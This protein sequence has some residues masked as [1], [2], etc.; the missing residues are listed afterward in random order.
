MT[1]QELNKKVDSFVAKYNGKTKGYP[2]DSQFSGECLSI[3]KL[4]IKEIFGISP[5][6]SGTNSAYGYWT[7]FPN[8]LGEVF[9]KVSY[10]KEAV[11][12]KGSIPIWKPT[13]SNSYGHIEIAIDEN[14]TVNDF[15]SFGQNWGG[16]HSHIQRHKYTGIIGWLKPK[17]QV[18]EEMT[19][20]EANILKFLKEQ[21]ANEGKVREAFGALSDLPGL[22]STI[23]EQS[24]KIE[25]LESSQKDLELRLSEL[26]AKLEATLKSEASWQ[27]Q[28]TTANNKLSK[29]EEELITVK[30]ERQDWKNKCENKLQETMDKQPTPVLLNELWSRLLKV[31]GNK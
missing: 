13:S 27:R 21:G 20:Q 22:K 7:N 8:P 31:L 3:V 2:T 25:T 28:Y 14:P 29:I 24:K 5:P 6:P 12:T 23:S 9:E 30:E 16:R 10:T 1:Q 11:I 15:L 19:E 18:Q 17:L 26:E 4:Y